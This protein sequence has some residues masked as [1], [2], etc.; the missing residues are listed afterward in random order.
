[1]LNIEQRHLYGD[2]MGPEPLE[3]S[4]HI[5]PSVTEMALGEEDGR[6][7]NEVLASDNSTATQISPWRPFWDE[8]LVGARD[9]SMDIEACSFRVFSYFADILF[10]IRYRLYFF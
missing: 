2:V 3:N 7:M 8:Q 6:K 9:V 1:M 4:R 10:S 5:D